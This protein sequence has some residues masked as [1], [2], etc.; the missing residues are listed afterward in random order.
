MKP[1]IL[2]LCAVDFTLDKFLARLCFRL[3]REGFDVTAACTESHYM[4][5][6]RQKG[7]RCVNLPIDRSMSLKAH[8]RSYRELSRWL[9]R[10]SFDIIHVHTPIASLIGRLA[11]ARHRVPLRIYTAH[12]FY[13]HDDM[14]PLKKRFHIN[15]ERF[16]A[17]LDHFLF[18]QSEEDRQSAIRLGIKKPEKVRAIGNGVDM[19]MFNPHRFSQADRRATRAKWN[20]PENAK[21]LGIIGRLVREKGY[22]ELFDAARMLADRFPDFRLMVIGDALASDHDD[23]TAALQKH[24]DALKLRDRVVFTG[25]RT[26][27]PELL[28]A[29]DVYTLPSWR[30][31]MP[32]SI[33]E[34]MAMGLPCVATN[35]RGCR[36]EIVHGETG[37]IVPVRDA[38]ALAQRGGQLLSDPELARQMGEAGLQR[39]RQLYDEE[40]V[41]QKQLEVIYALMDAKGTAR[42]TVTK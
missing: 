9:S 10:E 24:L 14:A 28:Q 39:A 15:L 12:G 17:R 2:Q 8:S 32:R 29:C 6:L 1:R 18:T 30:E 11:A 41:F 3:Q 36:E 21:V 31:G 5:P 16:G 38:Q 7:L 35:I 33:I 23:S 13:F 19:E 26:D 40:R 20:I 4:G 34:A 25:Q 27:I 42:P 22:F 37:Y